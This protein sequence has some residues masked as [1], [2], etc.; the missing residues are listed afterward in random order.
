MK[1]IKSLGL[2]ISTLFFATSVQAGII[3]STL[4]DTQAT[5]GSA[6]A[7][8]FD[9]WYFSM[10][11]AGT[12]TFDIM[13]WEI[14]EREAGT[15]EDLNGDGEARFVDTMLILMRDDGELDASDILDSN[16]DAF[17]FG[18][19]PTIY[20]YDSY[21]STELAAGNYALIV[22]S[23]FGDIDYENQ[24]QN[25]GYVGGLVPSANPF[26][27][28][29]YAHNLEGTLY[30][31]A[32]THGDYQLTYSDNVG[33]LSHNAVNVSEPNSVVMV[34]LGLFGLAR[35]RKTK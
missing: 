19:D 28:Y 27:E 8:T 22:A 14:I 25:G 4:F 16:D 17:V 15:F 12:A 20:H 2:S 30:D 9:T 32:V 33:K 5:D 18:T 13:S 26:E 11:Q 10:F 24:V 34:A 21:L 23:A 7:I 35:H 29:R 6:S 31:P 3:N 1:L